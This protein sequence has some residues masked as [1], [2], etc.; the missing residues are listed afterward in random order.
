MKCNKEGT[1][2]TA[3]NGTHIIFI[4]HHQAV[5]LIFFVSSEAVFDKITDV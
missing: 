4:C 5:I 3:L 2:T 1:K